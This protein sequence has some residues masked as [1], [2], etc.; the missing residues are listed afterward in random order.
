M[1]NGF[2]DFLKNFVSLRWVCSGLTRYQFS[3][4]LADFD[5]RVMT[6][7][8]ENVVCY[9][10]YVPKIC[11]TLKFKALRNITRRAPCCVQKE[12]GVCGDFIFSD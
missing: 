11:Q 6:F 10:K 9:K 5:L 7:L 2:E 1:A 3:Q 4:K 12:G 8:K